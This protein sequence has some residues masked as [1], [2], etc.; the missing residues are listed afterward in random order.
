ML[1]TLHPVF[2]ARRAKLRHLRRRGAR[3]VSLVEYAFILMIF[4]G[5]LFGISGF[6]HALYVYHAVNTAAK[7]GAR[8]AAVNGANCRIDSSCNGTYGMNNGPAQA[9]D[10]TAYVTARLPAS[11]DQTLVYVNPT[12]SAPVGSSPPVCTGPVTAPD[13]TT[14]PTTPNYPGCTVSVE[15]DYPYNFYFP[16]LPSVTTTTA[17]CKSPGLCMSSTSELIIAH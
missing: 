16:L 17:P 13:G 14:V 4:L 6:G 3:G 12:W 8:W 2:S 7:E 9:T 11:L 10:I 15:V 5:L 1:P